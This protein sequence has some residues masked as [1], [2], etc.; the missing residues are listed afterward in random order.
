M[1]QPGCRRPRPSWLTEPVV[2]K[3]FT[4]PPPAALWHRRRLLQLRQVPR[5]ASRGKMSSAAPTSWRLPAEKIVV[6]SYQAVGVPVK[7][8]FSRVIR[9]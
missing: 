3:S 4:P 7:T 1:C 6:R 8:R 2:E 9:G 5:R